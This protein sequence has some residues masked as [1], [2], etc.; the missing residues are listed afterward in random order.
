MI[1]VRKS[2]ILSQLNQCISSGLRSTRIPYRMLSNFVKIVEVGPR[3]GLQNEAKI[4]ATS[5]KIELINRLAKT[6]LKAIEATSFVSPKWVPQMADH[7]E[8]MRGITKEEGVRYPVLTP[9]IKGFSTAIEAG[10]EEVAV[11]CAVSEAFSQKNINCSIEE[12]LNRFSSVLEASK[13]HNIPVRGYLSCVLGCPYQGNVPA[14][15]VVKI[16]VKLLDMGCYEI[17]LGDTIGVG[18]AAKMKRLIK[19]MKCDIPPDKIAVHCH[20]TYGQALSNIVTAL[21]QDVRV[22]DSSVSGLGGC[23]YAK[24]ASGNVATEDVVYM[25]QE[26][27]LETGVDLNKLV[28]VGV[29]ISD[30]LSRQTVS[31]V[32]LAISSC[33]KP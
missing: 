24:G 13:Q 6:G 14:S 33:K 1:L 30:K 15:D 19:S 8:V 16:A 23:P 11:F 9:N 2:M 5:T 31:K 21:D 32:G 27:G 17:S 4:I 18:T 26:S 29:F 28:E 3:D 25:L 20:D 7:V 12:S 22:V 10:A